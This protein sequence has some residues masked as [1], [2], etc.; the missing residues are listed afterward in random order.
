MMTHHQQENKNTFIFNLHIQS[1]TQTVRQ[2]KYKFR[3][4]I[5][6]VHT[7]T[8][9]TYISRYSSKDRYDLEKELA[10]EFEKDMTQAF[11]FYRGSTKKNSAQ[12][13]TFYYV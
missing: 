4:V 12:T 6:P 1:G 11:I 5:K 2:E 10:E 7:Y 13:V 8:I 3:D 9:Y